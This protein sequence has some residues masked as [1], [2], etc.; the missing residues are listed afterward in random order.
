MTLLVGQA[1]VPRL[2]PMTECI[3][4]MEGALSALAD[5][6]AGLPLRQIVSL[7]AGGLLASMPA[8][9][10]GR[11]VFGVKAISVFHANAGTPFDSHQGSILLFETAN[12]R[13]LAIV[14]AT[15]VT[16]IRTAAVSAAAT[17]LL[18]RPGASRL[19]LI[20]AG[21]QARTHLDALRLVRPVARVR[22]FSRNAEH[23]R[24]FARSAQE[25]HG[26]E[27]I[28]AAT[29]REAVAGADIVCT[30]TSS[31]TPVV[32]GA[33]LAPGAHVNVVGAATPACREVD[34]EAVVRSRV[35]VD[36]RESA[37]AEA[38]DLLIPLRE[39]AIDVGHVR[40]ELGEILTGRARGR[41]SETEIT[42]F[43]S[44]GL[45]IEDV[46]AAQVVLRNAERLGAGT[47]VDLG[48]MRHG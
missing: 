41:E 3:E 27:V 48:G 28:A 12:G 10:A 39:G 2:L 7:P 31:C 24:A 35:F 29:P 1:E 22:V 21:V 25:S 20:G 30:L 23:A 38:G 8:H 42:L 46:A 4:A 16:A 47:R 43:K 6:E 34:T 14:D 44:L 19:A 37:L 5:G 17:R 9:L 40:A 26:L 15:S 33:W 13:L 11:G 18:A 45:A 36:R 32:E